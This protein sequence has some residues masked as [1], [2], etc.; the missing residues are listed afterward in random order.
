[1][2]SSPRMSR[3]DRL[4]LID[5]LETRQLRDEDYD[6]PGCLLKQGLKPLERV[7][8]FARTPAGSSHCK[9]GMRGGSP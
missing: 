4:D 2:T 7:T 3:K 8:P 5:R 9:R 1:M 6:T